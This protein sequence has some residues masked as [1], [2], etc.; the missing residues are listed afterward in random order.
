MECGPPFVLLPKASHMLGVGLI[1]IDTHK[2]PHA[3][4]Y[5]IFFADTEMPKKT[6]Q[7][8]QRQELRKTDKIAE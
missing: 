8:V 6:E 3:K 1:Y 2:K 7:A 4:M 5:T